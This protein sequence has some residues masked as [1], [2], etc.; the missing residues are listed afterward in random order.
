MEGDDSR[1]RLSV[2]LLGPLRA[3]VGAS[4]PPLGPPL[5]RAVL[6]VLAVR[7]DQVVYRG[8]LIDAVWGENLPRDPAGGLHTYVAGLRRVLEPVR[9]PRSPGRHIQSH[10]SGYRL[11]LSP[12]GSDLAVFERLRDQGRANWRAGRNEAAERLFGEALGLFEGPPLGGVPGPF[13]GT[14]RSWLT[15][16]RQS[17]AGDLV[18]V[19]L[20]QRRH[21]EAI[22]A[23][24]RLADEE[25]LRERTWAQLMLALYRDG[26]QADALG[27]FDRARA[28]LAEALGLDP[29]PQLGALRQ[30]IVESDPTL[31][32]DAGAGRGIGAVRGA[33]AVW[34]REG[35]LPAPGQEGAWPVPG[36]GGSRPVPEP[37]GPQ[38]A[39]RPVGHRSV[40]GPDGL[41][42]VPGPRGRRPVPEK[43]A[44]GAGAPWIN[45]PRGADHFTGRAVE[46]GR[47]A[48]AAERSG[49]CAID[50]MAG[51]GKTALAVYA[52][53][54]LQHGYP[55]VRLYLDLHGHT[56]GRPPLTAAAALEK[57]LL[58]V[59]VP[60]EHVPAEPDDRAALWRSRLAGLRALL[61]LDNVV[62]ARQVRPLL[63]GSAA[64]L[65]L[66][67]S[68]RRLSGLDAG[69]VLSLGMLPHPDAVALL[70]AVAGPDR[71]AAEP[72]AAD[73]VVRA[74]GGL[75]LAV[76]IAAA[77]LRHRP[78]WT[79]SHVRDRLA[80]EDRRL[81]ELAVEDRSVA[82]AFALSYRSLE[83][84][85]RRMFR[86]L[87]LFPGTE[88]GLHAAAALAETA[89]AV[90]DRLLEGL[91]DC[92]LLDGP[93]PGRYRLHDLLKV[94]AARECGR[95]EEVAD[96]SAALGGL[97]DTYL[98][99]V[100]DAEERLRPRRLD[101]ADPGLPTTGPDF[102]DRTAALEWLDAERG[103]FAPLITAAARTGR[104]RHAWQLARFLWGF[105]ETRGHWA[106]WITC[107]EL[108]LPSARLLDDRLAEARLLVGL[109]VA[110]H[111]L[112]HYPAAVGHYTAALA[113]MREAGFRSGEAGVLTNLGNTSRRM[114]QPTEAIGY[115]Q[116]ALEICRES[117]DQAGE[118]IA[119]ANLGELYCDAGLLS[120][121]VTALEQALAMFRTWD[122]RRPEGSV[123]D[124][125]ARTHLAA[126][127]PEQALAFGRKALECRR[128]SGDRSG[129]AQT[130]DLLGQIHHARAE[131]EPAVRRWQQALLLAEELGSPTAAEIRLRLAPVLSRPGR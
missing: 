5:R 18:D 53:R 123:L 85:E 19:L 14:Q 26:R 59:G 39:P 122:E 11:L 60:G 87:G 88:I 75:P 37:G 57:L 8:D 79:L 43:P 7:R 107:L 94:Y 4:E 103:N 63:P 65:V 1:I 102:E 110:R 6:A 58:A 116:G 92:Q 95:T 27:S 24:R 121:S 109:G 64:S 93:R 119:L 125:L 72:V 35:G 82:A 105:F 70:G 113:L 13:A 86:L 115:Q 22:A 17:V 40:P 68:R 91:V 127:D 30:R 3:F 46:A 101:R 36:P 15:E 55:D 83:P 42:S 28:A 76:Q 98:A 38:P 29:G 20:A 112:R 61:V 52:A 84:A 111:N 97:L 50:G 129:E 49:V 73:E 80:D 66:L 78:G 114:G 130:L 44:A 33:V 54:R 126:E 96:R 10:A 9:P 2:R 34:R 48:A 104:H 47:I 124:A 67:T 45:L 25:P 71:V 77:R 131:E 21:D 12:E 32:D 90:T 74:C 100:D 23:T 69:E 118:A 120:Q 89:P 128:I 56:P 16:Q 41:R 106:E 108:A 81:D 51:V 62:D 99:A 117:G 31:L